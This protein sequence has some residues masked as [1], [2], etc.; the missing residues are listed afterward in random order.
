PYV[1][2]STGRRAPSPDLVA[3]LSDDLAAAHMGL[4]VCGA[5]DDPALPAALARVAQQLGYPI[6]A[7]PLSGVRRG[8]HDRALVLD[9]YDAFLR[10]PDTVD[11]L[12]PRVVLRLGALPTSKPVLQ[13]LQRYATA[14]QIVVD[15]GGWRDPTGLASDMLHMDPLLLCEA[16]A[17]SLAAPAGPSTWT[18]AW[19]EINAV[20]RRSIELKLDSLDEPFEGKL[21]SAAALPTLLPAGSLLYAGNSMPVRDLDTFLPAAPESLRCLANRGANGID[22]IV[23]SALGASAAGLGRVVL[24]IGDVSFYHDLNG[25]LAARQHGLDLLV[26]LVNNDGGGIFSFLPQ[27]ELVS[28][29]FETLFGTPHGL[30]FRPFVEGWAD[31][32]PT[33]AASARGIWID[34]IG[35]GRSAAPDEPAR[36]SLDWSTRDLSALLDA[37]EIDTVDVLGYSMGGRAALH[38]AVYAPERV[39]RLILESASPG[40]EDTA[41]RRQRADA[42]S[43]LADRILDAG[44]DAFVAQ[45]ERQPLL[46]LAP[47]VSAAVRAEQ[48][49]QRLRNDPVGLANSLRGMGTGQQAPL[50]SY[51]PRV[52]PPVLLIVGEHDARYRQIAERMRSVLPCAAVEVVPQAGH[53]VHLDR[54][55]AFVDLVK[56][57]LLEPASTTN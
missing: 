35:H 54:P 36:Y 15:P 3:R 43:A 29:D 17:A 13:Y 19:C 12:A 57:A 30:D 2:V 14:R 1:S 51:L 10:D 42:D 21:F 31:V 45:W 26:V 20:A 28:D 53:T 27:A 6:L 18:R 55:A 4:I 22:G 39:R 52:R 48:H 41:E 40:I 44:L 47:H 46:Q 11:Q 24:V 8:A 7:D 50:W 23:S 5:Q 38:F 34:A 49:A 25:L 16:L 32:R 9:A 33:I 56:T 37:L